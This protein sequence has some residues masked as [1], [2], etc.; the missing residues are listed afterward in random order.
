[1]FL[2]EFQELASGRFG[3]ADQL[4][5]QLR[6]SLQRSP[7]V[8][9]LFAGSL[10][11]VMRDLF[12]P[13]DRALSQFGSYYPLSAIEPEEWRRG[14]SERFGRSEIRTADSALERIFEASEGHPRTTM[15]IA[16][17]S[18]VEL[19]ERGE[20]YLDDAVVLTGIRRA[21]RADALRHHQLLEQINNSGRF[22]Q[23]IA[24][25]IA[26]GRSPYKGIA[27]EQVRRTLAALE[28]L[29]VTERGEARGSWRITEPLLRR[30]LAAR[31][32]EREGA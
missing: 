31:P 18:H 10:E 25:E 24:Q 7:R 16:Q 13:S 30:Y 15:L 14:L 9:T 8:S 19:V 6:A 32:G 11:H 5:K 26:V 20:R 21:T 22:G 27:P 28:Q 12:G 4:T 23:R 17:Q 1:M 29:G 2:D 3:E